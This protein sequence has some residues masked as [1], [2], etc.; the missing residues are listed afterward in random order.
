MSV[1]RTTRSYLTL[2]RG[3]VPPGRMT[4]E[5][6]SF[7]DQVEV[8]QHVT[9]MID[10][11]HLNTDLSYRWDRLR[12][13][14]CQSNMYISHQ[15]VWL[16]PYVYPLTRNE[17]YR[18][19]RQA[20]YMSATVGDPGDLARRLG[21]RPIEKIAVPPEHADKSSGRRLIVMNRTSDDSDIPARMSSALLGAIRR[22]PKSVWLCTSEREAIAL[23]QVVAEWL[24][25]NGIKGHRTWL[26]TALGDEIDQFREATSGHLFVAGR[27]DG[28]DFS[29]GQCRIVVLRTLPKAVNLQEE[30]LVS[31]LGDTGFMRRRLNQ[32]IVQA[33]GRC[34]RAED[35]YGLYFLADQ[36]FATH[37]S[38]EAN[39]DGIPQHICAEL[40]LA[41]DLSEKENDELVSYA[42]GFLDREFSE[43]DKDIEVLRA[44]LPDTQPHEDLG[45]TSRD[46]VVAWAALFGSENYDIARKRFEKCWNE[47]KGDNLRETAALHGWHWAKSLFLAG[48]QGDDAAREKALQVL[49]EAIDRGGRQSWFNRM[50]GSLNRARVR[51]EGESG[52]LTEGEYADVV[53]RRFDDEL[54][55]RGTRGPG[56]QRFIDRFREGLESASHPQYL[57]GL[58]QLGNLLGYS[59]KRPRH[60]AATDCVWRGEF[61]SVRECVTFEAKIEDDTSNSI[62]ASDLGQAHNQRSRADAEFGQ[63]GYSVRATI[64]THLT[65]VSDDARSAVGD[66]RIVPKDVLLELAD[67]VVSLLGEYRSKWSLDDVRVRTVAAHQIRGR[68]P[69]T[70]WLLRCLD[71]A[72]PWVSSET[73]LGEWS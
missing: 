48:R 13:K 45:D 61:G 18:H 23:E 9:E 36:R 29:G 57:E 69:K 11:A 5:L 66:I 52:Q 73:L 20:L 39:R 41:Q 19:T 68:L 64:V 33:L 4:G 65:E 3:E 58:E 56:F 71:S 30:F 59:A 17:Y 55:R 49:K 14:I 31:C 15:A 50:R 27:F 62:T 22:H 6:V 40:D 24:E 46:E 8:A 16:R 21:T 26:L 25:C 47:A 2:S 32:R 42:S 70:G 12:P 60:S 10:A 37:F 51:D 38:R 54:E 35:D 72:E 67:C 28:M 43:Y 34:N 63:R 1:F 44:E 7:I 53:I